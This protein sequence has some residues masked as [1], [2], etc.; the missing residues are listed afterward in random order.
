MKQPNWFNCNPCSCEQAGFCERHNTEKTSP[1]WAE[2]VRNSFHRHQLDEN[3]LLKKN[4][5]YLS[6]EDL[7]KDTYNIISK[8]K[9][10]KYIIG[11][12]RSGLLPATIISTAIHKPLYSIN[13]YTLEIKNLGGGVRFDGVS[14]GDTIYLID[15]SSWTGN[16]TIELK[17]KISSKIKEE[18]KTVSIY[19][20]HLTYKNIDI[21]SRLIHPW[22]LFEWN[23][24]NTAYNNAYDIDGLLCRDFTLKEDDD[25]ELYIK[26]IKNMELTKIQPR[27]KPVIFITAR[28]EKYRSITEEWL[29]SN[30]F[31][32]KELIM[33]PWKTKEERE[34]IN[35][36]EWKAHQFNQC[37]ADI[38]I[39]SS[40]YLAKEISKYTHKM[41]ICPESKTVYCT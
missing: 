38:Y 7:V 8:I 33:G 40:D 21:Y 36:G 28:L 12:V 3:N 4:F 1:Q 13:Q 41:V 23:L 37:D 19:S 34:S 20:S 35:I 9:N 30:G 32:I 26:T 39:E 17:K 22:H 25:G 6:T 18:I 27:K 16:S 31:M 2:C 14:S 24:Y 10:C 5:V 29:I 11:V 15:D